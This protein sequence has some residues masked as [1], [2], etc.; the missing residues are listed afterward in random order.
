MVRISFQVP[1]QLLS[2]FNLVK[3]PYAPVFMYR[4]NIHQWE[5][6]TLLRL[7]FEFR[8]KSALKQSSSVK[9]KALLT[10][11]IADSDQIPCADPLTGFNRR[12]QAVS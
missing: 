8:I 11:R 6:I 9:P 2:E 3:M 10:S 4:I 12:V 5:M 1:G 7:F